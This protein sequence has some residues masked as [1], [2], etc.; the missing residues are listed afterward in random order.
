MICLLGN[1]GNK[2]AGTRHNLPWTLPEENSR[3]NG[4]WKG[5]FQGSFAQIRGTVILKPETFMNLS[6]RSVQSAMTF[7]KIRAEELLMIH[8][9]L[10]LPFGGY[11]WKMGGGTAGHKGLKSV[12]QSLGT[13]EFARLRLGIGRPVHGPV[14]NWVLQPFSEE[15]RVWIPRLWESVEDQLTGCLVGFDPPWDKKQYFM[16]FGN[17]GKKRR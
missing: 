1:P 4:S 17:T 3:W 10:E 6:G 8:D 12:G 16:D 11:C 7:F 9:D 2:Y 14:A 5:K 13:G 15:E